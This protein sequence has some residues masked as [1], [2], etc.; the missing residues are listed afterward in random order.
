MGCR[1]PNMEKLSPES[2]VYPVSQRRGEGELGGEGACPWEREVPIG[3]LPTLWEWVWK[4][5]EGMGAPTSPARLS[6]L[7]L[8]L[9][10]PP[11]PWAP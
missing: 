2:E 1:K 7:F 9:P 4:N 5:R 8:P 3:P 10:P 11:S 6:G